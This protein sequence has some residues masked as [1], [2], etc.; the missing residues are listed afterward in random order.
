[1]NESSLVYETIADFSGGMDHSKAISDMS[2]QAST[3]LK[4]VEVRQGRHIGSRAGHKLYTNTTIREHN[5]NQALEGFYEYNYGGSKIF[6]IPCNGRVYTYDPTT[7]AYTD[8]GRTYTKG[9]LNH[10]V[11]H[12]STVVMYNG[13]DAPQS[14]NGTTWTTLSSAPVATMSEAFMGN[15]FWND[16]SDPSKVTFSEYR[17]GASYPAT[18]FRDVS[19]SKFDAMRA[20]RKV[21]DAVGGLGFSRRESWTLIGRTHNDFA[22]YPLASGVGCV[23][24][25]TL[26]ISDGIPIWLD[27]KGFYTIGPNNMPVRFKQMDSIF[28]DVDYSRITKAWARILDPGP[29]KSKQYVCGITLGTGASSN[30]YLFVYDFDVGCWRIDTGLPCDVLAV[31]L[32]S[33]GRDVL[34]GLGIDGKIYQ[35]YT[36]T[37]DNGNAIDTS[38][39]SYPFYFRQQLGERGAS[40]KKQLTGFDI[41]YRSKYASTLQL[42]VTADTHGQVASHGPTGSILGYHAQT[43]SAEPAMPAQ[44]SIDTAKSTTHFLRTKYLDIAKV[45]VNVTGNYF[46]LRMDCNDGE[47]DWEVFKIIARAKPIGIR[48]LP[49]IVT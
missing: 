33:N 7:G 27:V 31:G 45:D 10:F 34:Y 36:G 42:I 23:A 22:F 39:I 19:E 24:H 46:Q 13:V 6:I 2:P 38:W 49:E 17:N 37:S 9:N 32:D 5:L 11:E 8:T 21:N 4:N 43:L 20:I 30:N 25:E 18:Y 26:Q 44:Y 29:N 48:A 15:L 47:Q 14:Y 40:F 35:L 12:A 1:M 28:I 41:F 16:V 3:L